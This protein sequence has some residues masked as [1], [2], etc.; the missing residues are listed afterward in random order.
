LF[1]L[2][3][4]STM[5]NTREETPRACAVADEEVTGKR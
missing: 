3:S 4:R 1:L 2:A 5:P